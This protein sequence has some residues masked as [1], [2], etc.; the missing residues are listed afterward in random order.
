MRLKE[1]SRS[2]SQWR[3]QSSRKQDPQQLD[4]TTGSLKHDTKTRRQEDSTIDPR[5]TPEVET[6]TF[7]QHQMELCCSRVSAANLNVLQGNQ[8][9]RNH[10]MRIHCPHYLFSWP[11][12]TSEEL[13]LYLLHKLYSTTSINRIYSRK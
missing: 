10:N 11:L 2:N 13:L 7:T 5:Q 1:F 4:H 6:A 3:H 8:F 12:S 9:D